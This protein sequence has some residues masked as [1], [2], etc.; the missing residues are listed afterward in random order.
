MKIA[1]AT[2]VYYP[3]INGVAV[4]SHNLAK[5]LAA[6][7]HEVMVLCPSPTGE[8]KVE[9]QDGVKV[10]YLRARELKAYPDQIHN[11]EKLPPRRILG[12]KIPRGYRYGFRIA[13]FPNRAVAEAL[14]RFQP[15]VVHVQVADLIG[16][17]AV[18]WARQNGVP[19][20]STEHNQPEVLVRPLGIPKFLRQP[21]EGFLANYFVRRQNQSDFATMP[22]EEAIDN[23]VLTP[24]RE[25]KVPIAAVS[26]GVDLS[27]F[28]PSKAVAEIYQKYRISPELPTVLYVGRVDPEKRVELVLEAF[29]KAV[30][31]MEKHQKAQERPEE[32]QDK[33]A[34][35]RK[36][37]AQ[38]VIVGDGVAREKLEKRARELGIDDA[39]RF[40]RRVVPPDLYELYKVGDVFATASEIE[41]QGIVLIEAAA[42][43]LPLIAVDKGAVREICEDGENGFLCAPEATEE[44]SAAMVKI[45]SDQKLQQKFSK[46]S[47]KKAQEHDLERTLKRFENI[48]ERVRKKKNQAR[49]LEFD[50]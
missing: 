6:R 32:K 11:P 13:L 39:V 50:K 38:L 31:K 12:M 18:S 35:Q 33:T 9:K 23:L 27:H 14:D 29:A 4:F 10:V 42:T 36:P 43:G 25:L 3:M 15:D 28:A 2:A 1:I 21:L 5:G 8:A 19:V 34:K 30:Q 16:R 44:L 40:L 17:T 45:L 48:Y 7:G 22:T 49:Y 47:L 24:G 46:N 41:T 20:V 37:V 26:N